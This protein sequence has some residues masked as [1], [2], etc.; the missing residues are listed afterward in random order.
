[1]VTAAIGRTQ[2]GSHAG[3]GRARRGSGNGTTSF[4]LSQRPGLQSF[5]CGPHQPASDSRSDAPAT[6]CHGAADSG[7]RFSATLRRAPW[8]DS[9]W[10]DW[11]VPLEHLRRRAQAVIASDR[12]GHREGLLG[13][14]ERGNHR[15]PGNN[16]MILEIRRSDGFAGGAHQAR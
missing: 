16:S 15:R 7:G 1:M 10:E 3:L 2:G 11:C 4:P 8:P 9:R 14:P 13:D 12:T 5:A 6:P